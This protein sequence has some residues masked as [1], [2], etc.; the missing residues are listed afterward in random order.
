MG[1]REITAQIIEDRMRR[2]IQTVEPEAERL[3][4][5][6]GGRVTHAEG[7]LYE[8]YLMC[9]WPSVMLYWPPH[10]LSVYVSAS[11]QEDSLVLF[12]VFLL[13]GSTQELHLVYSY[14]LSSPDG[15]LEEY[16]TLC[17]A[18]EG[19]YVLREKPDVLRHRDD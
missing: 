3:L 4:V 1:K 8:E 17:L 19:E 6:R 12:A 14:R 2:V 15:P 9:Y 5:E 11:G 7:Y 13:P 16:F 18:Q 10:T